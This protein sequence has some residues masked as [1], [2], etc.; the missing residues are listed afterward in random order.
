MNAK[1][2]MVLREHAQSKGAFIVVWDSS[3]HAPVYELHEIDDTMAG[4]CPSPC[5]W[6]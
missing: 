3:G 6:A 4:P 5:A 2:G 1:K